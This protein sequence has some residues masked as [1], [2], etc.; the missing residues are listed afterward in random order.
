MLVKRTGSRGLSKTDQGPRVGC[1][2]CR[3][4]TLSRPYESAA[5]GVPS[6]SLGSVS[7]APSAG[8]WSSCQLL[9]VR[10]ATLL[11]LELLES[12][13]RCFQN[14]SSPPNLLHMR[15]MTRPKGSCAPGVVTVLSVPSAAVDH[16]GLST[17]FR[18][19][20]PWPTCKGGQSAR[21]VTSTPSEY[22]RTGGSH[23]GV[24]FRF[25]S[26]QEHGTWAITQRCQ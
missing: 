3:F 17:I 14:V 2:R 19:A 13:S 15:C 16:S 9:R 11:T 8:L 5:S 20:V 25:L 21:S 10:S 12:V 1:H 4:C 24:A 18:A 26:R 22:S 6:V 23:A 7:S